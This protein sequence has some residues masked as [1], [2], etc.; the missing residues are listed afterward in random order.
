MTIQIYIQCDIKG[1]IKVKFSL[2]NTAEIL[3]IVHVSNA[4]RLCYLSVVFVCR[5][6][7]TAVA[8]SGVV[9]KDWMERPPHS[10]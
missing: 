10:Q 3:Y 8:R 2:G 7:P 6:D 5:S 4:L 1:F 9:W